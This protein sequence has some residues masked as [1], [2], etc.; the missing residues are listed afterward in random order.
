MLGYSP[1]IGAL[2]AGDRSRMALG[3]VVTGNYFQVL[4]VAG[5]ARPHAAARG[6]PAGR[7]ACRGDLACHWAARL[8]PRCRGA[9]P[10]AADPR[11]AV[12]DRR[13]RARRRSPGW[14]RCCSPSCGRRSRG[15]TTSSRP[16]SRTSCPSPTGT[17]RLDR[18]GQRWLFVKGRLKDGETA[19]RAE[20][21]LQ[22]LMA[23]LAGDAPEDERAAPDRD[24]RQRSH[25]SPGRPDAAPV[26][27]GLMIAI[28]LVLLVACANVANMLLARASGRQREIG[29]RLAIGASRRR[30]VRQLLTESLVLAALGA[31]AGITLRRAS[32]SRR[33]R[34]CRCRS[35]FRS[36]SNLHI[37]ARVVLFTTLVATAA[38]LLAGL[39]PALRATR[40]NLAA[41]MK[42]DAMIARA[43]RRWTI[44]DGLVVLQTAVTLVLLVAAGPADAQHPAGAARRPRL[45]RRRR[46]GARHGAGPDRLH[47]G[48]APPLFARAAERVAAIPGRDLRLARGAAA[49]R[50]QLQPQH[51]L[52][53]GTDG[54]RTTAARRSRRPGS[55]TSTSRRSASR[56]C[57]DATSRPAETPAS[58]KVAI[59]NEAFVRRYWPGEDGARPAF[60][61]A[62]RGRPGVRGHRRRRRLQGRN[63]RRDSRRPTST[64]R[65]ASGSS[66]AKC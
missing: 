8:R 15:S 50:H 35:P 49:A 48:S 56:C 44:R 40:V 11:P 10:H 47:R 39:A 63:G 34:R 41:D 19:A 54:A 5:R 46:G 43:G 55:T 28:G 53:P 9:R 37:D 4:G 6:R 42:G 32:R 64:M 27:A 12:H 1:S 2:K 3:E 57:A 61:H 26:A 24:G 16:A 23:Q 17:T 60:P 58:A 52:L 62:R 29:I 30:L 38:G 22:V 33:S 14:C 45:P 13:R 59:V 18:R 20:A 21:N 31:F 36:R 51:R 7:A 25:S 66:P 65:S